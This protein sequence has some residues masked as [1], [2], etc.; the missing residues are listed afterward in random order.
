MKCSSRLCINSS[1]KDRSFKKFL[2]YSHALTKL[3]AIWPF[4][5]NHCV[6]FV[7]HTDTTSTLLA[8]GVTSGSIGWQPEC[9]HQAL[10]KRSKPICNPVMVYRSSFSSYLKVY[11]T[12]IFQFNVALGDQPGART[13][14]PSAE[15]RGCLFLQKSVAQSGCQISVL[16]RESKQNYDCMEQ[17]KREKLSSEF[18]LISGWVNFGSAWFGTSI[19]MCILRSSPGP[20]IFSPTHFEK[21]KRSCF[22]LGIQRASSTIILLQLKAVP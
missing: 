21:E 8:W 14:N 5:V 6:G 19:Y 12:R 15:L 4:N 7:F 9:C 11:K 20:V 2:P 3:N 18:G 17:Y 1:K 16:S 10:I 13:N 22:V